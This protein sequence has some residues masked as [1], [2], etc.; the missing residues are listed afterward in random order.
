MPS[1]KPNTFIIADDCSQFAPYSETPIVLEATL[2][3]CFLE[4][5]I[6]HATTMFL[7]KDMEDFKPENL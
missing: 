7:Y 6:I 4:V 2:D 5:G 3:I 1:R